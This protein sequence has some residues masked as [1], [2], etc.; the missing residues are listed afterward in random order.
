MVLKG[1]H[2][3]GFDALVHEIN[4]RHLEYILMGY[5]TQEPFWKT[6]S[7]ENIAPLDPDKPFVGWSGITPIAVLFQYISGL[8]GNV[9]HTTLEGTVRLLDVRNPAEMH[10]ILD[11]RCEKRMSPKSNR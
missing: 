11:L 10:G 6:I 7:T 3:A 5:E 1:I 2:T 4:R 8:K 9:L